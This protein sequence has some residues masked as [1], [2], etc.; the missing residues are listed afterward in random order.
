MEATTAPTSSEQRADANISPALMA[1]MAN[2]FVAIVREMENTMLRTARSAVI[3]MGRDFTCT[4]L[5]ADDELLAAAEGLVVHLF[6]THL[7]TAEMRRLHPNLKEGDAFLDND[8]YVGNT[9]HADHTILVPVFIDGQHVFT[10]CAKGHQPDCG[11]AE[12]TAYMV[13]ARDIYEEGALSLPCVQ[14]QKD[15]RDVDDVIR[16]CRQRIRIPEQWY[17]DYLAGVGAARTGER[18]LKGLVAKYGL[19]VVRQFVREWFDYSERRMA[20]AIREIPSGRYTGGTQLDTSVNSLGPIPLKVTI[21]VDGDAGMLEVDLRDS[22]DSVAAGVNLSR[23]TA[24]TAGVVGVFNNLDS[25]IPHNAGAMRRVRVVLREGCVAGISVH[26]ASCSAATT[27]V[28]DRAVNMIQAAFESAGPGHG[29]A[30]GG[31]GWAWPGTI[32]G[33]DWRTRRAYVNEVTLASMGGPAT[34]YGDGTINWGSPST[35]GMFHRDSVELFEQRYPAYVHA[36]HIVKDSGGAGKFRGGAASQSV[37][38]PR[39]TPMVIN[40]ATDGHDTPPRGIHGGHPGSR[41]PSLL[42]DQDGR[43]QPLP[44]AGEVVIQPGQRIVAGECSGAG[45]GD[46]LDRDVDRVHHDVLEGWVSIEQARDVYGV[47]FVGTPCD[48]TLAVDE[49]ETGRRRADLRAELPVERLPSVAPAAAVRQA[50]SR[51]RGQGNE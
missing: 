9:H 46:P 42:I 15:Y 34:A 31:L 5:T 20:A 14:V 38:S 35:A 11:N 32:A 7:Q 8:P 30:E 6:G 23:A 45:V 21:T 19:D 41:G 39:E 50:D 51:R 2:R 24:E 3:N 26:P 22:P 1:V 16:M 29:V 49:Q 43:E 25:E 40:W 27:L 4:I 28:F 44:V 33:I 17:G 12:P 48:E 37:L 18:R 47:I 10:A 13:S 36:L